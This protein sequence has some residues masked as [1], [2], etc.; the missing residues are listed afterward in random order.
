[1]D[2]V[3]EEDRALGQL[4]AVLGPLQHVP[5]LGRPASTALSSS[6]AAWAA[7]ATIRASVVLPEPGGP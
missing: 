6:R 1:M 4:P 5:H 3:E 2:L 7:A